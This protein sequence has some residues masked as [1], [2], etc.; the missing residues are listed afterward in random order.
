MPRKHPARCG[1][2][3]GFTGVKLWDHWRR[4]KELRAIGAC[5]LCGFR[6]AAAGFTG[7]KLLCA[8]CLSRGVSELA[9]MQIAA[10]RPAWT[11]PENEEARRE[12]HR[13]SRDPDAG[14]LISEET[15]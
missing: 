4:R 1:V 15:A 10:P 13:T 12:R 11:P 8:Y 14:A 7:R 3:E 5:H 6:L 9:A 2:A